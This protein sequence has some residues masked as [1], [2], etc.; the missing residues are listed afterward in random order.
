MNPRSRNGEA[1]LA[2]V[3]ALVLGGVGFYGGMRWGKSSIDADIA[4]HAADAAAAKEAARKSEVAA[5]ES[6]SA[7][8]AA[9]AADQ[10]RDQS[11]SGFALGTKLALDR[12]PTPS[13]NVKIA[14]AMNAEVMKA[15]P[16]P[17]DAQKTEYVRII[18]EL[19]KLNATTSQALGE[20]IREADTLQTKLG[21]ALKSA[22]EAHEKAVTSAQDVV[23]LTQ[24][25]SE[26]ATK[27]DILQKENGGLWGKIKLAIMILGGLW[28]AA[29][30][31]P[32]L[33]KAFPA[34]KPVASVVGGLWSPGVQAV[35]A[36][37]HKLGDDLVAFGEFAKTWIE[38]TTGKD[39][40]QDFKNEAKR[41]WGDDVDAQTAIER[42]KKRV[43]RA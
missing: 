1:T 21:T 28:L 32:P 34:L 22:A 25:V 7:H 3:L 30:V 23:A 40:L 5:R 14:Q 36:G 11:T 19:Q 2:L 27:I 41:W 24:K 8:E 17:T 38:K 26:Q 39:K 20:K 18:E 37:A 6:K 10:A 13:Q 35:S 4:K 43:L 9:L 42:I 16:P 12:E 15:L 33:A 29:A 31:L